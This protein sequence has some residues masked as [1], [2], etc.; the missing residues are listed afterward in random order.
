MFQILEN[1]VLIR[2]FHAIYCECQKNH[3]IIFPYFQQTLFCLTQITP[4]I[5]SVYIKNDKF[6]TKATVQAL[7]KSQKSIKSLKQDF[8]EIIRCEFKNSIEN[9]RKFTFDL[10]LSAPLKK[11]NVFPTTSSF[12]NSSNYVSTG[13]FN[14]NKTS[15]PCT[16]F[17]GTNQRFFLLTS[18]P[19][20]NK[21]ELSWVFYRYLLIIASQSKTN[22]IFPDFSD[23]S[24][25][26][27]E[28]SRPSDQW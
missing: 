26:P 8:I 4:R 27:G 15:T 13:S 25:S 2:T 12:W 10:H 7:N 17:P 9:K 28:R 5:N 24:A 16:E 11:W 3:L 21:L 23:Y 14:L 19:R 22:L 1:Q 6:H 18:M 20:I